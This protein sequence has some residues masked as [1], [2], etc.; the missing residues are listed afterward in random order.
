MSLTLD[1]MGS[2]CT[3]RTSAV[4]ELQVCDLQLKNTVDLPTTYTTA[5]MPISRVH[6]PTQEDI[7]EWPHLQDVELPQMDSPIDLLIGSNVADA[8]SPFEVRTGPQGS[9]HATLTRIGLI[10]WNVVRKLSTNS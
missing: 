9:P 6:I 3:I 10:L 8:Y 1:T 5:E 7:A 2:S 4:K